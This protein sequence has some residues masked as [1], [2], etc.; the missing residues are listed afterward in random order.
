MSQKSGSGTAVQ[1]SFPWRREDARHLLS[2]PLFNP[3]FSSEFIRG[4]LAPD[5]VC[6]H[7]AFIRH[8]IDRDPDLIFIK[9]R[10]DTFSLAN[11]ALT[12]VYGASE[13]ELRGKGDA[14]FNSDHAQIE[15]FQADDR[16]VL[17]TKQELIISSEDVTDSS[18]RT[19]K[20]RTIKVPILNA[21]GE[22]THVL[23][24][25]S[26]ITLEFDLSHPRLAAAEDSASEEAPLITSTERRS[27][28]PAQPTILVV[29]DDEAVSEVT[30]ELLEGAG[31]E[32]VVAADGLAGLEEF[33]RNEGSVRLVI[34]DIAMPRADGE[35]MLRQLRKVSP[36]L[37]VIVCSGYSESA[38][39]KRMVPQQFFAKPYDP[40]KL[41]ASVQKLLG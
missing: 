36:A 10:Q 22:A 31:Y 16:K 6:E 21:A 40:K 30:R 23:G 33:L 25:A 26:D 20:L 13:A 18:G 9:D 19:M 15:K 28:A 1:S 37:P 17:E 14:D 4:L 5:P 11:R 24:I 34:L 8:M 38:T 35:E 3:R 29:D 12:D 39:L 41:L 27:Q 32:V 2:S 7:T